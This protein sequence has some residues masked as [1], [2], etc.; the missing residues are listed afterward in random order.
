[1]F[2]KVYKEKDVFIEISKSEWNDFKFYADFVSRE[3]ISSQLHEALTE[4]GETNLLAC[5]TY[6]AD[7][8]Y[9]LE[10]NIEDFNRS[11]ILPFENL[12]LPARMVTKIIWRFSMVQ[13]IWSIHHCKNAGRI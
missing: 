2:A 8:Y 10:F 6:H 12:E 5:F 1:M 13:I 4:S 9:P 3:W 7:R 11:V